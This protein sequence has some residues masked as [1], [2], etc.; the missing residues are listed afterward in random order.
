[1]YI[2]VCGIAVKR[3][4]GTPNTGELQDIMIKINSVGHLDVCRVIVWL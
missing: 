2:I 3:Y 1:M 4:D